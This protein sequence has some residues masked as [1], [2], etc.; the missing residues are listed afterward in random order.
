MKIDDLSLSISVGKLKAGKSG[1]YNC[2]G[3]RRITALL[4]AEGW[5][6]NV[7]RVY[8]IWRWGAGSSPKATQAGQIMAQ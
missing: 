1:Q 5:H 2:Y 6:V 4:R 3:Y 8:R 7:K